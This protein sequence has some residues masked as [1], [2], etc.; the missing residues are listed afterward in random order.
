M[1]RDRTQTGCDQ[2]LGEG[3]LGEWSFL[4]GREGGDE[5]VLEPDTDGGCTTLGIYS[6]S[7]ND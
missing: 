2:G 3:G 7:L 6:I 5:N 4:E 1:H